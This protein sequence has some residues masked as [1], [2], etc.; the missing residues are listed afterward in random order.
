MTI[1]ITTSR[2][3]KVRYTNYR[4]ETSNREIQGREIFFGSNEYH[5]EPQ[6]LMR[7][8][9]ME[10]FVERVFAIRDMVPLP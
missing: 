6:W 4:G 2:P 10:R 7:G 1:K 3:M 8:I 5:P 9:D